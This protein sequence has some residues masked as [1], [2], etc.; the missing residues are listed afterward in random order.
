VKHTEKIIRY[1][2]E[3]AQK[4]L[5]RS[6]RGI[7]ATFRQRERSALMHL[8][9]PKDG[10]RILDAGCGAGFYAVD[11]RDNFN[12]KVTGIDISPKMIARIRAQGFEAQVARFDEF[13]TAEAYDG[14]LAAGVLEFVESPERAFNNAYAALKEGGRLVLLVPRGGLA[15]RLYAWTHAVFGCPT[16]VFSESEYRA[17][18]AAAGFK[19]LERVSC[20]PISIAISWRR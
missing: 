7:W 12:A 19:F 6:G 17:M 10:Q 13:K 9:A 14:I 20:T 15:G 18:A 2:D 8:L 5:Q 3:R 16:R 4:Y 1:F 11:L